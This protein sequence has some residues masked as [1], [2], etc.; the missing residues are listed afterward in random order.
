MKTNLNDCDKALVSVESKFTHEADDIRELMIWSYQCWIFMSV[1]GD[2]GYSRKS[3]PLTWCQCHT[4]TSGGCLEEN[5]HSSVYYN[6][7]EQRLNLLAIWPLFHKCDGKTGKDSSEVLV[8]RETH[9][10]KL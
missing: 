7:N 1:E 9:R 8:F 4:V 6:R 5:E 2:S 10:M 3:Q